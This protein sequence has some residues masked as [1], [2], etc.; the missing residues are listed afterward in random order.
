MRALKAGVLIAFGIAIGAAV[1]ASAKQTLPPL[2]QA[3]TPLCSMPD[4]LVYSP[5]A[6]VTFEGNRFRCFYVYN[7]DMK[8]TSMG[9]VK[10]RE[11]LVVDEE[12]LG[13]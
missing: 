7:S 9:W 3:Q 11:A 4:K 2:P 8:T 1:S 5:G 13:R 6:M 12:T 10:M